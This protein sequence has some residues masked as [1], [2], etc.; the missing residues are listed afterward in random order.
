MGIKILSIAK[1]ALLTIVLSLFFV[2]VLSLLS[3]FTNITDTTL[4][5]LVYASTVLSVF[6]GAFISVKITDT[7]ALFT[8]LLVSVMYYAFLLG[9]TFAINKGVAI[10]SHFITMTAGIFAS[11]IL[12]AVLGK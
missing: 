9:T 7:K 4:T 5:I 8:A 1:C 6:L 3:Y 12:G 10:N 2:F 11:G